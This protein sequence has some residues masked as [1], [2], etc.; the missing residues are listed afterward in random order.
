MDPK[1]RNSRKKNVSL[2]RL[3]PAVRGS[4]WQKN[5][6]FCCCCYC[7]WCCLAVLCW[8]SLN[9][10]FF[11]F[12]LLCARCWC[13]FTQFFFVKS[14]WIGRLAS[15]I[16]RITNDLYTYTVCIQMMGTHTHT[17][18]LDSVMKNYALIEFQILPIR[19]YEST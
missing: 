5:L 17:R 1:C 18:S 13:Y 9:V 14:K 4:V 19:R 2:S 8:I 16:S 7:W 10:V 6:S 12:P 15:Y 11:S 3:Q